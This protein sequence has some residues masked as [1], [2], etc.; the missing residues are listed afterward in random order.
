MDPSLIRPESWVLEDVVGLPFPT[1]FAIFEA[2]L[3]GSLLR[4]Q[5]LNSMVTGR[6]LRSIYWICYLLGFMGS[7]HPLLV[8]LDLICAEFY[9]PKTWCL[10]TRLNVLDF[11]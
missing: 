10:S 11:T 9:P 2:H 4:A 5:A 7:A 3:L 8:K 1:P 6:A